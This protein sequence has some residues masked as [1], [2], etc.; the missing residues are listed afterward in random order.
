MSQNMEL[1]VQALLERISSL[2]MQYENQVADLRVQL[3]NVSEERDALQAEKSAGA[4]GD[5]G[6]RGTDVVSGEVVGD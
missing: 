6:P 4:S 1:K 2:T 3:T 5:T